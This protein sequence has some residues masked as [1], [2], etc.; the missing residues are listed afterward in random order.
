MV[1]TTCTQSNTKS[2][3]FAPAY[4][5]KVRGRV[6]YAALRLGLFFPRNA[7]NSLLPHRQGIATSEPAAHSARPRALGREAVACLEV[8]CNLVRIRSHTRVPGRHD[9]VVAVRSEARVREI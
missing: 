7:R 5:Q 3:V 9:L 2:P 8:L 1:A 4:F 6:T